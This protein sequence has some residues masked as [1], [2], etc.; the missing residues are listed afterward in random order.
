MIYAWI[1]AIGFLVVGTWWVLKPE[2][3]GHQIGSQPSHVRMVDAPY[4]Q[5]AA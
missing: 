2:A 3:K 5:D 4:D 1:F